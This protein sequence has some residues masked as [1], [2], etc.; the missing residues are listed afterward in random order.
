MV[1]D[2]DNDDDEL[3]R[4]R[5]SLRGDAHARSGTVVEPTTLTQ[6]YM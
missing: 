4:R 6:K 5:P 3:L 1:G 2:D